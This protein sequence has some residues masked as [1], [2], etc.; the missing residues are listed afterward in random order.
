MF[1]YS[2]GISGM[3]LALCIDKR[4]SVHKRKDQ[5]ALLQPN[6]NW[7]CLSE[8]MKPHPKRSGS[9]AYTEIAEHLRADLIGANERIEALEAGATKDRQTISSLLADDLRTSE[10]LA[11]LKQTVWRFHRALPAGCECDTCCEVERSR[12]ELGEESIS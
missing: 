6:G 9:A 1:A 2:W 4:T 7:S 3:L 11:E 12:S 8:I 5:V 10:E